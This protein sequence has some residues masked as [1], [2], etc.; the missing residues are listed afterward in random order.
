M[1]LR[2]SENQLAATTESNTRLELDLADAREVIARLNRLIEV[3][4][5]SSL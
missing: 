4:N 1:I 3:V 5:V 2:G